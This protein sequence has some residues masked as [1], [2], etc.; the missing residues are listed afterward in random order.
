MPNPS[1]SDEQMRAEQAI[2]AQLAIDLDVEWRRDGPVIIR[3]PNGAQPEVDA[4]S[5]DGS[6]LVE[7]YAHQGP[8]KGGQLHKVAR[9][10]L[11]LITIAREMSAAK[12]HVAF[13]YEAAAKSASRG[14]LGEAF[15]LWGISRLVVGVPD[16]VRSDLEAAQERQRMV[17]AAGEDELSG[18]S[19]PTSTPADD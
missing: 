4:V 5:V 2:R 7:I 10:A 19:L 1:R 9:D 12:L 8:L 17:N 14:W 6:T 18:D 15:E 13:A 16:D 11:K 3:L